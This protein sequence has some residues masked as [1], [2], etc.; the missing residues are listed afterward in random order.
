MPECVEQFAFLAA[1]VHSANG[2][3]WNTRHRIFERDIEDDD[4][5]QPKLIDRNGLTDK[6]NRGHGIVKY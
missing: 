1:R 2:E 5:S 6:C 4:Q 3:E